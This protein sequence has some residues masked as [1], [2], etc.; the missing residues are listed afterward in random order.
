M[1]HFASEKIPTKLVSLLLMVAVAFFYI[2]VLARERVFL[3]AVDAIGS[4]EFPG[5]DPDVD[6]NDEDDLNSPNIPDGILDYLQYFIRVDH[7]LYDVLDGTPTV[8]Y[9]VAYI[10]KMKTDPTG[11]CPLPSPPKYA[12]DRL[13]TETELV[14]PFTV[15]GKTIS[16][17]GVTASQKLPVSYGIDAKKLNSSDLPNVIDDGEDGVPDYY[18]IQVN[19]VDYLRGAG[20]ADVPTAESGSGQEVYGILDS[21]GTYTAQHGKYYAYGSDHRRYMYDSLATAVKNTDLSG[22]SVAAYSVYIDFTE[23]IAEEEIAVVYALDANHNDIPDYR[24]GK[25]IILYDAP[26]GATATLTLNVIFDGTATYHYMVHGTVPTRNGYT[27]KGWQSSCDAATY[28]SGASMALAQGDINP[29]GDII[30][31]EAVWQVNNGGDDDA[32]TERDCRAET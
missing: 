12:Y 23:A 6:D 3:H 29:A 8:K 21:T 7:K 2:P 32:I 15:N 13:K 9:G 18:I 22:V 24:E 16:W 27:F 14:T 5:G 1:F 31:M 10:A 4:G 26:D 25:L 28:Q 20:D 30:Y 17:T 19:L 11:V